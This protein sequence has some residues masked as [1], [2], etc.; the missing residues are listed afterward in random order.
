MLNGVAS[1]DV[2]VVGFTFGTGTVSSVEPGSNKAVT[3]NITLNGTG[4]SNYT[5]T[6]PTDIT[7]SIS[8]A[9]LSSSSSIWSSS[10]GYTPSSSSTIWSSSSGYIP[11]S[12]SAKRSSSSSYIIPD[13]ITVAMRDSYGDDWNGA[14]LGISVNGTNLSPNATISSSYSDT[15]TFNANPGDIVEFYWIKGNYDDECAF[16]VYYTNNPPSPA[17]DPDSDALNDNARILLY[18]QYNSLSDVSTGTMLG[19]FTVLA[20]SSTIYS[21][22]S[23]IWSSSS[24]DYGTPIS[25]NPQIMLSNL[26]P[27]TKIEVYNLQ[28]KLVYSTTS[29]S[30]LATS[31][32]KIGVQTK[33]MYIVKIGTQIKRVV[34]R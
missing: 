1:G 30:P 27:N 32:L 6:Q 7:V 24:S 19:S 21:S 2:D 4:A 3:T 26:P 34:V 5:L 11:S 20:N 23:T 13:S 10:S 16:A 28:G 29:H 25:P 9:T 14:A 15:Y 31:H 8:E 12:S 17:F 22:S 33:G 18:R